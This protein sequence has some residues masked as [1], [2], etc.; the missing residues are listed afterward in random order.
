MYCN[1]KIE[2]RHKTRAAPWSN[3]R[4]G[5]GMR[6]LKKKIDTLH[7]FL[8]SVIWPTASL[9]TLL[10]TKQFSKT[11]CL[12]KLHFRCRFKYVQ[13]E[14]KNTSSEAAAT[15]Q[16]IRLQIRH[17]VTSYTDTTEAFFVFKSHAGSRNSSKCNFI[18]TQYKS[19]AFPVP[20]FTKLS[21]SQQHYVQNSYTKS[22]EIQT[23]I[24][25]NAK[26]AFICSRM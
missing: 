7:S 25:K 21:S 14:K 18:Y 16:L 8:V 4:T 1:A 22:Q 19:T 13:R 2:L 15:R 12:T 23:I 10:E 6:V 26:N 5:S 24:V 20:I 11:K 9:F 3:Y 17:S